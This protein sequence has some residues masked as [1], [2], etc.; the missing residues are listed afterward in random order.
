MILRY[1]STKHGI[2]ARRLK[3]GTG[4]SLPPR[5]VCHSMSLLTPYAHNINRDTVRS[6]MKLGIQSTIQGMCVPEVNGVTFDR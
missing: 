6:H 5:T 2:R 4:P 3:S 1:M